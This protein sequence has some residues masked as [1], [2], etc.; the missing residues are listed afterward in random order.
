MISEKKIII[1]TFISV[2]FGTTTIMKRKIAD[3][4]PIACN[5]YHIPETIVI[6]LYSVI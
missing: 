1:S 4:V 3:D 6:K 5:V 2:I